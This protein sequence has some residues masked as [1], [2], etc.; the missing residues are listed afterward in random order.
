MQ[1]LRTQLGEARL[2]AS[3][4]RTAAQRLSAVDHPLHNVFTGCTRP[5]LKET[6]KAIRLIEAT[7]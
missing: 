7:S 5:A 3:Y 6:N 2:K 4:A 1:Q